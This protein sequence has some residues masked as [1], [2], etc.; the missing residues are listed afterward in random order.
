MGSSEVQLESGQRGRGRGGGVGLLKHN[1]RHESVFPAEGDKSYFPLYG[2]AAVE[3]QA[4]PPALPP[5]G[6]SLFPGQPSP[7]TT[8]PHPQITES[9]LVIDY[10]HMSENKLK[11]KV[12]MGDV[13]GA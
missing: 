9:D 12:I 3:V 8:P 1:I 7:Y 5:M 13:P 10:L 6:D 11:G 2:D 4:A